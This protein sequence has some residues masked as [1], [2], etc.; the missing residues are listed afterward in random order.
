[1][2]KIDKKLK[3]FFLTKDNN[4]FKYLYLFLNKYLSKFSYK[5]SFSQGSMD[6]ILS[7]IFKKKTNGVYVDVGCQH[8]IKNNNTYLL[9]K[10]GWKGVNIDLD[11]VNIDLFKFNRPLDYNFN[12]AV[13]DKIEN[14]D[15][16][17]YHQKSPINTLDKNV[18]NKQNSKVEKIFKVKTN[19][20]SNI[21]DKTPLTNI[22]ILSIDVEGFELK[23]LKGLNFNK[24]KPK[25]IIVEF[26]DLEAI[27][28]E[29]PYNNLDKIIKSD[30]YKFIISKD[31]NFVNWVNGDLVFVSKYFEH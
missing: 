10:K 1:M 13:S 9:F 20:L 30:L 26:L 14:I 15:L 31:Y 5:K 4:F 27:K 6:L 7:T 16:Y 2:I 22:D 25:I 12:E 8:P 18:S 28:W 19:T 21:L 11:K 3:E 23:V 17:Y 24:Y 29:I